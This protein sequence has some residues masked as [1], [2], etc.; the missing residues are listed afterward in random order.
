[1]ESGPRTG[2]WRV[3]YRL[4]ERPLASVILPCGGK[5][6]LLRQCIDG[7]ADK[8]AYRPLEIVLVDNS[9]D[10]EV[11]RFHQS[12][13]SRRFPG[14]PYLD[15]RGQPFNYSKLNNEGVRAASGGMVLLL[16]DDIAPINHDWIEAL[17]E[18][19]QRP[20]VGAVGAKLLYP[21]GL[22]QH[23]GVVMGIFGSSGHAFKLA[24]GH[25]VHGWCCFG[26]PHLVRDASAVTAACLMVR[27]SV[28]DEAG[29]FDE[30]HLPVAFQDVDLCLKIQALGYRNVYTPFAKLYH[31]ESVTKTEKTPNP[32]ETSYLL[33]KWRAVI[34]HDPYYNPNLTRRTEDYAVRTQ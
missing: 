1:V 7:L 4:K 31:Y 18:H 10:D 9:R 33:S 34:D 6:N 19:A 21:N 29:G 2:T 5:V 15:C 32:V 27:R 22:I 28:Y 20:E 30:E 23:A 16:N 14:S 13:L 3:R 17:L 24:L 11:R 12:V 8:T 25:E 26:L